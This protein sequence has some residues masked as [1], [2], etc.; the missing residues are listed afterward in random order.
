MKINLDFCEFLLSLAVNCVDLLSLNSSIGTDQWRIQRWGDARNVC[1]P[2]L[3]LIS[4]SRSFRL[5][6][7]LIR[8]HSSRMRTARSSSRPAPPPPEQ[9]LLDQAPPWEQAPPQTRRPPEQTPPVDRHTPVN[10]LPCPKL[11]LRAVIIVCCPHHGNP[12]SAIINF[13]E[14]AKLLI[15]FTQYINAT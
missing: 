10:I 15:S 1:P 12:G 2:H 13:K 7:C 8:M 3:G 6:I 11:R 9:A 14:N 4:F 5:K